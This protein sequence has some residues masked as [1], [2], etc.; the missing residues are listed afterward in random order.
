M[1]IDHRN[2]RLIAQILV[3][4]MFVLLIAEGV[5]LP[6]S[7]LE[8]RLRFL[9]FSPL[10]LIPLS[11]Y[12]LFRFCVCPDCRSVLPWRYKPPYCPYC[13]KKLDYSK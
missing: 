6:D 11:Y 5:L 2:V 12:L 3:A 9:I 4:L 1:K 10:L 8:S 13:G 7:I